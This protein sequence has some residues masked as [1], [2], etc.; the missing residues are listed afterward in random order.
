MSRL[1]TIR[2]RLPL[3]MLRGGA[4]SRRPQRE[5]DLRSIA[6]ELGRSPSGQDLLDHAR[7]LVITAM[8]DEFFREGLQLVDLPEDWTRSTL[9]H[10]HLDE[11]LDYRA[12]MDRSLHALDLEADPEPI[13]HLRQQLDSPAAADRVGLTVETAGAIA[14]ALVHA[15]ARLEQREA[16]GTGT[17]QV[18]PTRLRTHVETLRAAAEGQLRRMVTVPQELRV[19]QHRLS[20]VEAHEEE[21]REEGLFRDADQEPSGQTTGSSSGASGTAG[22]SGTTGSARSAGPTGS[23]RSGSSTGSSAAEEK[24]RTLGERATAIKDFLDSD[25]GRWTVDLLSK[26]A[27]AAAA[28]PALREA[29]LRALKRSA[30]GRGKRR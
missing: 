1:R 12:F 11:D 13:A 26:G 8:R 14:V 22:A 6:P 4:I 25:T 3:P 23:A 28:N 18:S 7:G 2:D 5:P 9:L 20:M 29:G 19:A 21:M 24:L 30:T 17:G 10:A 16:G 27:A 15:A